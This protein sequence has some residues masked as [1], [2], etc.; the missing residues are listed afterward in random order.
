MNNDSRRES[1]M[2]TSHNPLEAGSKLGAYQIRAVLGRGGFGITY[3]AK[4]TKLNYLVALKEYFPTEF[5]VRKG[6]RQVHAKTEALKARFDWGRDRFIM[7]AQ[8]L[9]K[10]RHPNIVRVM[11]LF[12]RNN[13]AYMVMDYEKGNNLSKVLHRRGTLPEDELLSILAP[14]LAGL[15]VLHGTGFIH[16]D[17]KPENIILRSDNTPVLIDFGSARN[18]LKRQTKAMT[19]L[20]TPG[21]SPLEQYYSTSDDQGP[22]TD[23]YS[24]GAVLYRAI[25]GEPPAEAALRSSSALSGRSDPLRAAVI[26]GEER[27]SK[28]FLEAIDV[29]LQVL[30]KD[31]PQ[32]ISEW[33]GI[34]LAGSQTQDLPTLAPSEDTPQEQEEDIS[35]I[36][37]V[38]KDNFPPKDRAPLGELFSN[39]LVLT[40][41]KTH[42][43]TD[44]SVLSECSIPT[45]S[46]LAEGVK[47][48]EH[49]KKEPVQLVLVDEHL[50]DMT[51]L[52]FLK[53][54]RKMDA[55]LPAVL[56]SDVKRKGV[57]IDAVARSAM[58]VLFRPFDAHEL[59]EHVEAAGMY[60]RFY[61]EEADKLVAAKTLIQE[62]RYPE[63]FKAF[64]SITEIIEEPQEFYDSAFL[65]ML[66]ND[67]GKGAMLFKKG[68]KI[69]YL[70]S[71]ALLGMSDA[72]N[73][74]GDKKG[75]KVHG[76]KAVEQVNRF[77][78]LEDMKRI[79]LGIL[80]KEAHIP[81]PLNTLGVKLRRKGDFTGAI[82]IYKL[83]LQHSPNDPRVYY[84]LARVMA[85]NLD[86]ETALEYIVTSLDLNPHFKKAAELYRMISGKKWSP[87]PDPDRPYRSL[88][89]VNLEDT[90]VDE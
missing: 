54:M 42:A 47:G 63:A 62:T 9:A 64:E 31:R 36:T 58:G 32:S 69:G 55:F 74:A 75:Y 66:D 60:V 2:A 48:L 67:F 61:K 24:L 10:F 35:H 65:A 76:F 3:L 57:L 15:E 26:V 52:K 85:S 1:R 17:I 28:W 59:A 87:K 44:R 56:I 70:L 14:L 23:I 34:L 41:K 71:E 39:A 78:R 77:N 20:L 80:K 21:Y 83:A 8:I 84:N 4:D 18:A 11:N 43:H 51:G 73:R 81:N 7:E 90:L 27:Y 33:R 49:L 5:A 29:A 30:E 53:R 22:W 45:V 72:C 46:A 88:T 16:R 79:F 37:L 13:T 86:T 40:N 19:T 89:G 25:S 38:Y 12:E 6:K 68:A 82:H 50:K